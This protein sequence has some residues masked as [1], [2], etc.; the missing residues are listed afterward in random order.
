MAFVFPR[1]HLCCCGCSL[2]IGIYIIAFINLLLYL[3]VYGLE[4]TY[5]VRRILRN[6]YQIGEV[7]FLEASETHLLILGEIIFTGYLFYA[8][9]KNNPSYM[10]PFMLIKTAMLALMFIHLIVTVIL[11]ASGIFYFQEALITIV[12][13]VKIFYMLVIVYS[14]YR[15]LKEGQMTSY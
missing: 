15:N 1:V 3:F 6:S 7:Q 13:I 4:I 11:H 14:Q 9:F 8:N 5:T 12:V 10:M 2:R